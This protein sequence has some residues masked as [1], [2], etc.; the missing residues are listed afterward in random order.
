MS[1]RPQDPNDE[2][3]EVLLARIKAE[4][5]ESGPR[6]GDRGRKAKGP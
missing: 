5:G 4:A 3:A 1:D 2:P 6:K